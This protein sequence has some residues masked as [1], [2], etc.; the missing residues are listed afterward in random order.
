MKTDLRVT[1]SPRLPKHRQVYEFLLNQINSGRYPAGSRLPPETELPSQ[2]GASLQTTR[3]ALQELVRNGLLIRRRGDGTYVA[4]QKE[5]PLIDG[6]TLRVGLLLPRDINHRNHYYS[7][8]GEICRGILNQWGLGELPYRQKTRSKMGSTCCE[9]PQPKRGLF[10]ECLGESNETAERRP[11]L[12]D[13][14]AGRYDALIIIGIIEVGWIKEVLDLNLPTVIVDFPNA[15]FRSQADIVFGDAYD[16]Y[17]AA[18]AHLVRMGLR[19]IH[20]VG[21]KKWLPSQPGESV[22]EWA[23]T[24]S[25]TRLDPDCLL[26]LSAYRQGMDAMGIGVRDTWLHLTQTGERYVLDLADKLATLPPDEQPEALVCQD[27]GLANFMVKNCGARGLQILGVG[28]SSKPQPG[29]ALNVLL[30]GEEM[31]RVAAELALAR[32]MRPHRPFLN[33]GVRMTFTSGET[34]EG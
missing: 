9:W 33:V 19:R 25:Q 5:P 15:P 6:R 20:Y 16:G 32:L 18:I 21:S 14:K 28:A 23:L 27:A 10:V 11:S 24:R 2:V 17:E 1:V 34:H 22:Q 7:F 29:P 12:E 30:D 31:G 3:L 4:D 13:V 26:R 8:D